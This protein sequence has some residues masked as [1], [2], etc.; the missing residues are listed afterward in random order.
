MVQPSSINK[1]L[2]YHLVNYVL[3]LMYGVHHAELDVWNVWGLGLSDIGERKSHSLW[4]PATSWPF[5]LSGKDVETQAG[6]NTFELDKYK[7]HG[8]FTII[9]LCQAAFFYASPGSHLFEFYPDKVRGRR[10]KMLK[11][12]EVTIFSSS[13]VIDHGYLQH[14]DQN[15]R[16][17]TAYGIIC[18]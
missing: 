12:E 10:V 7:L 15:S 9:T 4:V 8:F 5:L 14:A 2:V 16:R 1:L 11:M 17:N 3:W 18:T 6:H 13:V